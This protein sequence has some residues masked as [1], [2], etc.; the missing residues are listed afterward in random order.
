MLTRGKQIIYVP[1]HAN[2]PE[3]LDAEEGFV[4]SVD[5]DFA[6]CRF[7]HPDRPNQLRTVANSERTPVE[8]LVIQD[9]RP[10]YLVRQMLDLHC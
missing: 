9:T 1:M 7:W 5:G 10:A 8:N 6:Y 2:G 3:H 4:T